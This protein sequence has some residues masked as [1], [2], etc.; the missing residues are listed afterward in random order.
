MNSTHY[1]IVWVRNASLFF[2]AFHNGNPNRNE[3]KL[4][5]ILA[6]SSVLNLKFSGL[7]IDS[8]IADSP[9]FGEDWSWVDSLLRWSWMKWNAPS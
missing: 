7:Q 1:G 3:E 4:R 5:F 6:S 9:H 2:K 8:K